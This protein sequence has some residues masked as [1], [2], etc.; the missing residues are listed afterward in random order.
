MLKMLFSGQ[1]RKAWLAG[2]AALLTALITGNQDGKL[3]VT[4]WLTAAL[5]AVLALGAVFGVRNKEKVI[6]E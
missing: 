2:T 4:D 5:A 1:S 6:E 3:D